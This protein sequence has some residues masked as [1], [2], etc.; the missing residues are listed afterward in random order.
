M[1]VSILLLVSV[2]IE[3]YLMVKQTLFDV[4]ITLYHTH[5]LLVIDLSKLLALVSMGEL[6]C[7]MPWSLGSHALVVLIDVWA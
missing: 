6:L 1:P 3:E 5:S 7:H 4:F 2:L